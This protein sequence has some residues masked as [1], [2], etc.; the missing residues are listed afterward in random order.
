MSLRRLRFSGLGTVDIGG[1][2]G[3]ALGVDL[4][5]LGLLGRGLDLGCVCCFGLFFEDMLAEG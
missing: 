3:L 2:L 5:G 1:I 4:E